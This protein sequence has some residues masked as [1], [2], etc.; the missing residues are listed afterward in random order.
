MTL[1]VLP[2]RPPGDTLAGHAGATLRLALP[3]MVARLGLLL[4]VTVDTAMTG[5]AGG[6]EL[7]YYG[8][9]TAP[10]V[11]MLLVGIGLLISVPVLTAQADGAGRPAECGAVWRVGLR[12]AAVCGLLLTVLCQ[13]G[14]PFLRLIG[15][16][17]E[18]ARGGAAV[19]AMFGWG[20]PGALLYSATA[21]FLE[22][23]NR[24]TPGMVIMLCANVLN[25]ALNWLLIYGH[26][27][28]PAMGA[29][30]AAL[31]TTL[32]RWFMFAALAGYA[33]LR[34]DHRHWGLA[35]AIPDARAIGRRLR[36]I[37]Y[38]M[39]LSHGLETS[40]FSAMVLFAGLLG[41][42]HVAGYQIA[43]NLVALVFMCSIGIATAGSVRIAGALGRR[44]APNA[45]RAGWVALGLALLMLG[46]VSA[47]F[48]AHAAWLASIYTDDAALLAVAVPTIGVAA[49]VIVPDGAQSVLIGA[50]RGVADVWPAT[51]RY[52]VSFWL[53]M[54]PLG[55]LLGVHWGG[56]APGLMQGVLVG[57]LAAALSLGA[58]FHSV[59]KALPQRP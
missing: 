3:V 38:P 5:H 32:V 11:P 37:G 59:A 40:A 18:L 7:A 36:R 31:A 58:R 53:V 42:E 27:G 1:P 20:L 39:A 50:L 28:L 43:M 49:L 25:A 34:L 35:G 6:L 54:T 29:E 23:I 21:F 51:L 4:L 24:A 8:I 14:E 47:G 26:A 19:L 41:P 12:H 46:S 55:Y 52:L 10:Q 13:L 22:A 56:G 16:P 44:D 57:C 15:Q 30:G 45:R 9:A 48:H 2:A 17:P 33:L